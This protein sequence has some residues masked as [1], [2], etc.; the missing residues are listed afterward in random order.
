MLFLFWFYDSCF[1]YLYYWKT[2]KQD[3]ST[4]LKIFWQKVNFSKTIH[5]FSYQ[6]DFVDFQNFSREFF[7]A[8]WFLEKSEK[9]YEYFLKKK[10]DLKVYWTFSP[11]SFVGCFVLLWF[12]GPKKTS[13]IFLLEN[14]VLLYLH[15]EKQQLLIL[16]VAGTQFNSE[17][18]GWHLS[19]GSPSTTFN[20]R[21]SFQNKKTNSFCF[22]DS[23]NL[24]TS[25][26]CPICY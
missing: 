9:Y 11:Q 6:N 26:N 12:L 4:K 25:R 13:E 10:L 15:A 16:V 21:K 17:K 7:L 14:F 1:R 2:Q 22:H 20:V 24:M 3:F 8:L 5:I 19:S 18:I 23:R